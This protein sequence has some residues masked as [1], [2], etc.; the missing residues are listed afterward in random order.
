GPPGVQGWEGNRG[1]MGPK[2]N[3]TMTKVLK[4]VKGQQA[5]NIDSKGETGITGFPGPRVSMGEPGDP[6][7]SGSDGPK[8]VRGDPGELISSGSPWPDGDHG[9]C[10]CSSEMFP[11]GLPGP[12]GEPAPT[13][14]CLDDLKATC[15]LMLLC[16]FGSTIYRAKDPGENLETKGS[17]DGPVHL[18]LLGLWEYQVKTLQVSKD[19]MVH[20][21]MKASLAMMEFRE[22]LEVR[23]RSGS[24][25]PSC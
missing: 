12:A 15:F 10:N 13:S 1:P 4:G 23:V 6:G 20:P 22:H 21:E 16:L 24:P 25:P 11:R 8:G 5:D 3:G 2:V 19:S 9:G 17:L 18:V 7:L 14:F